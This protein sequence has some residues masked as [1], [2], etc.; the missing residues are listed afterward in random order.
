MVSHTRDFLNS[1][2]NDIIHL[3]DLQLHVYRGN[4]DDFERGYEQKRT[5][6]NMKHDIYE[7][8]VKA[9]QRRGDRVQQEKV[10]DHAKATAAREASKAKGKVDDDAPMLEAPRK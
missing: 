3:H 5:E 7:K 6:M 1:V 8:Q 4:F 10:K 2:C 9:V